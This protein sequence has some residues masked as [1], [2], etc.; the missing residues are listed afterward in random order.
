[1]QV[2]NRI[3]AMPLGKAIAMMFA[4]GAI[5]IW[6]KH[7]SQQNHKIEKC[8]RWANNILC[9]F[10]CLLIVYMTLWGRTPGQRT[11]VLMPF[12]TLTTIPYNN[13]AVRTMI[14]NMALFLPLGLTLPY[15]LGNVKD[16]QRKWIC[17]LLVG[18][19]ISIAVEVAQYCF[20]L[21]QAETDDVI[22]N[23]L[24][25]GVGI[26]ADCVSKIEMYNKKIVK[27]TGIVLAL[28]AIIACPFYVL[29]HLIPGELNT[30]DNLLTFIGLFIAYFT[31]WAT[32][33]IAVFIYWLQKRSDEREDK[34]KIEQA[35]AAMLLELD[36]AF[37]MY[38]FV[39]ERER[40]KHCCNGI[41]DVLSTNAGELRKAL[42]PQEF[43]LLVEIVNTIRKHDVQ[44]AK[45]YFRDWLQMV[46]LS[47][48]QK[49]FLYIPE[50]TECLE[51]NTFEL[52]TKLR[53][54]KS[55]YEELNK[56]E[57]REKKIVF[58]RQGEYV[59]IIYDGEIQLDGKL[60]YDNIYGEP[61]IIEGFG[62]N[63]RYAGYYKD[64]YYEGNGTQF[65]RSG[66]K[67]REGTWATGKLISGTEYNWLI[68]VTGGK[69]IYKKVCPKDPY[70]ATDDFEYE[71]FE[72]YDEDI[73]CPLNMSKEYIEQD[74]I[75]EYYIVD[76][77]VT[78]STEQMTNIRTLKDFLEKNNLD[79]LKEIWD[80]IGV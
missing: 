52:V 80:H 19:G 77:N 36:N 20:A 50:Y 12:H 78:E 51:K 35:K 18:C 45:R 76:M 37:E 70:D 58:E 42:N 73:I 49:Y 68:H 74:S 6:M 63:G 15:V 29:F 71:K 14:M 61:A 17:C 48:F 2:M 9:I 34:R 13:E 64:G 47:E 23:T 67:L 3:Y 38:L 11:L 28:M 55:K 22:C 40:D 26:L 5:W 24:G 39:P 16:A 1:M 8:W 30:T 56:I 69:L 46:Y 33:F 10:G 7:M 27:W 43:H 54:K 65:G 44:G 62:R 21:G 31:F 60:G 25:C 57:N 79:L 4:A 72:L 53:G 75:D 41:K 66:K 32:I 59:R